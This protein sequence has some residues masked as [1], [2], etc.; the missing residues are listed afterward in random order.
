MSGFLITAAPLHRPACDLKAIKHKTF[1]KTRPAPSSPRPCDASPGNYDNNS[2]VVGG[3]G[4]PGPGGRVQG[5]GVERDRS[6]W[7]PGPRRSPINPLHHRG[8]SQPSVQEHLFV[9]LPEAIN[10]GVM[11]KRSRGL[12]RSGEVRRALLET[13]ASSG[14]C[15]RVTL[16]PAPD[17]F[18]PLPPPPR[19]PVEN[20]AKKKKKKSTGSIC[21]APAVVS[22]AGRGEGA[23]G[24]MTVPRGSRSGKPDHS[25]HASCLPSFASSRRN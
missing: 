17:S 10:K 19:L 9:L 1:C 2:A 23:R 14:I 7:P 16:T 13:S 24:L 8:R 25:S 21:R 5:A 18:G 20:V 22:P 3:T 6:R 12:H 15:D 11:G 4:G